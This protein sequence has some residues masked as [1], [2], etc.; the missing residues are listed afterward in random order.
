LLGG[1]WAAR[2]P[3]VFFC[4]ILFTLRSLRGVSLSLFRAILR[5]LLPVATALVIGGAWILF[6]ALPAKV[7]FRLAEGVS[8]KHQLRFVLHHPD[9]IFVA[10]CNTL[11]GV[12]VAHFKQFIG[13][14]GW[15][16]TYLP[17]LYYSL[18]C[19]ALLIAGL[20]SLVQ[21][22][23]GDRPHTSKLSLGI[24]F[25]AVSAVTW[26][27][28]YGTLYLV[29]TKVGADSVDGIQGRYFLASA[30]ALAVA[31]PAF[32]S[33][34]S[35]LGKPRAAGQIQT[36]AWSLLITIVVF[37]DLALPHAVLIRYY[38]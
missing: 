21:G 36:F 38:G 14:L 15:S 30:M 2:P 13:I 19:A 37:L 5:K 34:F 1:I 17:D 12:F 27:A 29:W 10:I 22:W 16:D 32:G 31:V 7:P 9:T 25:A 18:A 26:A 20:A 24:V 28:V 35:K 11:K 6:G 3:Y 8:A 4:P 33:S 23:M